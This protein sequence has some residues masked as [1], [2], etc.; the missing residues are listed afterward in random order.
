MIASRRSLCSFLVP[1][2]PLFWS[3][4]EGGTPRETLIGEFEVL[5]DLCL[6]DRAEL[7][8][9]EIWVTVQEDARGP[10]APGGVW[11][12][13][14]RSRALGGL[15]SGGVRGAVLLSVCVD[16]LRYASVQKL[17]PPGQQSARASAL[18]ALQGLDL[19]PPDWEPSPWALEALQA[20]ASR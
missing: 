10:I 18:H 14:A 11:E 16:L 7:S 1:L 3:R 12:C 17:L 19:D 9:M 20:R 15:D 2:L 5:R 13:A 4:V 8:L 6:R